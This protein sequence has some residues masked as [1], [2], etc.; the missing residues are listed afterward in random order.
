[1]PVSWGGE[2]GRETKKPKE[3]GTSEHSLIAAA[4]STTTD[5]WAGQ[6]SE[7]TSSTVDI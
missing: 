1:M 6:N 4:K 7:L 3:A 2:R 5:Q